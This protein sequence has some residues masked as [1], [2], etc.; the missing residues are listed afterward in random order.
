MVFPEKDCECAGHW[1]LKTEI[2]E[3]YYLTYLLPDSHER[4]PLQKK[5]G[6]IF[7]C[8]SASKNNILEGLRS[9]IEKFGPRVWRYLQT[10]A[11]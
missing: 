3:L 9:G 1:H 6:R 11:K 4:I 2:T 8:H 10:G 7:S 5:I